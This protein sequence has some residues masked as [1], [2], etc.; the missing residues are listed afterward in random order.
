MMLLPILLT[1][2]Y[3]YVL[4]THYMSS[5]EPDSYDLWLLE[6]NDLEIVE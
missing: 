5:G 1:A 2:G 3:Y 4:K 6:P